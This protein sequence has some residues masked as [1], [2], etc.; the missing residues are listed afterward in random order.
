MSFYCG[1][2]KAVVMAKTREIR[3]VKDFP[4]LGSSDP[5]VVLN[6]NPDHWVSVS[7]FSVGPK[8]E[9]SA[10]AAALRILDGTSVAWPADKYVARIENLVR[11]DGKW[12]VYVAFRSEYPEYALGGAKAV[13]STLPAGDASAEVDVDDE[14]DED[15][16]DENVPSISAQQFREP[17]SV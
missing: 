9:K 11:E 14:D 8:G 15:D 6:A 4:E 2:R 12:E 5:K 3:L 10:K 1:R 16:E 7:Y 17:A 13:K